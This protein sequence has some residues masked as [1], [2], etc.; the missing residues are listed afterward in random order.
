MDILAQC[1]R[2]K[3][4]LQAAEDLLKAGNFIEYLPAC[5]SLVRKAPMASLYASMAHAYFCTG[6]VGE[7]VSL[8]VL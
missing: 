5:K 2:L 4:E 7:A 8:P 1:L 6:D 3:T